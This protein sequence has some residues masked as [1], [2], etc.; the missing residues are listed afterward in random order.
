MVLCFQAI[1]HQLRTCLFSS[2]S[3]YVFSPLLMT[4][5]LLLRLAS[6]NRLLEASVMLPLQA[7]W[8]GSRSCAYSLLSIFVGCNWWA[9]KAVKGTHIW[10]GKRNNELLISLFLFA[11]SYTHMRDETVYDWAPCW[12]RT[13]DAHCCSYF[14]HFAHVIWLRLI[15]IVWST[16]CLPLF[17]RQVTY[18]INS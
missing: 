18:S 3:L 4:Q 15:W 8:R 1:N 17:Q 14:T 6:T 5:N 7:I 9:D 2:S 13:G 12:N 16:V 11:I 10:Q